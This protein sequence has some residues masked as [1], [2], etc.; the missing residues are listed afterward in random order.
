MDVPLSDLLGAHRAQAL[1]EA[2]AAQSH[3]PC[4]CHDWFW[5]QG[6][7][8]LVARPP[9]PGQPFTAQRRERAVLKS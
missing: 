8:V 9:Q 7:W 4:S 2:I 5:R 3:Y 6:D 1:R